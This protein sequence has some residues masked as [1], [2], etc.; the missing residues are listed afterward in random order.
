MALTYRELIEN[1][2]A[3]PDE[4]LDDAVTIYA[5]GLDEYYPL[6]DDYPFCTADPE[7]NDVL[8]GGH[9]YLII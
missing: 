3:L 2:K 8:D 9:P 6:V 1:L 7:I 5:S 4:R